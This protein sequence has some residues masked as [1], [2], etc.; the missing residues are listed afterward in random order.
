MS[1]G[2]FFL[3]CCLH[4]V[5]WIGL[6]IVAAIVM[7]WSVPL[8][9]AGMIPTAVCFVLVLV[10]AIAVISG[11]VTLIT[12]GGTDSWNN[13]KDTPFARRANRFLGL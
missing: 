7:F 6:I 1:P 13:H 8:M 4:M 2:K 12:Y 10:G 11:M 9:V 5:S 3:K